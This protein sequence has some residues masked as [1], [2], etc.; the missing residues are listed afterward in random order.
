VQPGVT[1]VSQVPVKAVAVSVHVAKAAGAGAPAAPPEPLK[2]R[3]P[4]ATEVLAQ[5]QERWNLGEPSAALGLLQSAVSRLEPAGASEATAL[6]ALTREYVRMTLSQ[7]QLTAA[8]SMLTRLELPLAGVADIWALRGNVAQ[9]L[10][11]HP[12]AVQAYLKALELRPNEPRWM[13]GA[14]VSLAQQGQT[15]PAGELAEMARQAGALRP[16]VANCLRQLGV[17]LRAD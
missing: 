1:E 5:A 9:R 2:P 17:V 4:A 16:D 7:G 3:L 15:G 11:R 12:E 6:A 10:G 14:A 8:W 13:L